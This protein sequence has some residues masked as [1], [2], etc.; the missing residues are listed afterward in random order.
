[1]SITS[2]PF[3]VDHVIRYAEYL[4]GCAKEQSKGKPNDWLWRDIEES[5]AHYIHCTEQCANGPR[6]KVASHRNN[7]DSS[8][9]RAL[10][11]LLALGKLNDCV[12][13]GNIFVSKLLD[14]RENEKSLED[15]VHDVRD[16]LWKKD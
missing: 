6:A 4:L 5:V 8:E 15:L 16:L 9:T 13:D 14:V 12:P 7:A 1:M 11:G 2:K 10:A 3:Y